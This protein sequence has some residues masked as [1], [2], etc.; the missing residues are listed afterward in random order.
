M[1]DSLTAQKSQDFKPNVR[2]ETKASRTTLS[3]DLD[4]Q[5]ER[6]Q[7]Q[8]ARTLWRLSIE[9]SG[10]VAAVVA[11]V[12]MYV[13]FIVYPVAHPPLNAFLMSIFGRGNAAIWPMQIIWYTSAAAMIGLAF[14]PRRLA[15][16]LICLLAAAN[17]VWVGIVYF[18]VIDSSMGTLD[19]V[20]NLAWLWAA[21]FILEA[22]L[23]LVAGLLRRDLVFAPRWNLSSVLGALFMCYALV[24]YPI[25]EMLGGQPL[26]ASPLFGLSP[27]VTVFFTFGLLL[28]ARPPA[29]KYL[30]LLPLAWALEATPGNIAMGHVAD[31]P[32]ILVGAITVGLII[33]RD[34]TA[35]WQTVV[36]GLL[37]ALMIALS[38]HDDLV[39]G[40]ALVLTAMTLVQTIRGG[41]QQLRAER[42][43]QPERRLSP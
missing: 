10:L 33:W 18:G 8:D 12:A 4:T 37:L 32:L 1:A 19:G 16:Q 3:T 14:W 6:G 9:L 5:G 22:I 43:Q 39:I 42:P 29:P 35:R 21:L 20:I 28:W 27:C 40:T 34:C 31:F 30:L 17:F 2:L 11:T 7:P 23:L 26:S 13:V 38:G 25:I 41:A 36:A 24:A 15:S